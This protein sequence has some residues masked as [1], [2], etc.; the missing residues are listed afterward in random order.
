M[1]NY[2]H[3]I[4]KSR[5][6]RFLEDQGRRETWD[7]T[8][9]RYINYFKDRTEGNSSIPWDDLRAAIYNHEVMP[10]MRAMMTAGK[11][12]DRDAVAGY[13]C[14]Y[15]AIDHP[16]AFDE[17]L[18]ILMCGTGVGFSVERQ[19]INKLPEVAEELY[20]TE[21]TI[22]VGDS[23]LGWAKA[24]KQLISMLYDGDIPK[25][26]MSKV[27]PAGARLKTFGGRASGPEP[28]TDLF[29]FTVE[30]FKQAKGRKLNSIEC[31]DI[32]C[33]VADVVICGGV[34]R[35]A[36][37]SLSNLTDE[38]MRNAKSGEWWNTQGQRALANNSVCYTEK[39]DIGIFMREWH[40]LYESKS[41]ERGM[42][43][44]VAS[45]KM[46]PERRDK[47]HDFGTNPSLRKGTKVWT[48]D[49]IFPIEQLEGKSFKVKN[50]NGEISDAICWLSG[51]DVPLYEISLFGG[52]KYYATAEHKWP[53]VVDKKQR[54]IKKFDTKS[55][56]P[57]M[58]LPVADTM[59]MLTEGKKGSYDDGFIV[60]WNL[61]D[62]WITERKN[63]LKQIGFIVS[64]NDK[65][66]GI[67]QMITD[68]LREKCNYS[69]DGFV[70]GRTELN[71]NSQ[72]LRELFS[73]HGV[74][75]KSK[76]LPE[77]VWTSASEEFRRG[78][79]NGLFSSDGSIASSGVGR[80][81]K[82]VLTSSHEKLISDVSELLGFYGIKTSIR[83]STNVSSFPNGKK[84]NREYERFD[85]VIED[86]YSKKVFNKLFSLS[87]QDKKQLLDDDV[88]LVTEETVGQLA[89]NNR[90]LVK[91]K[92]IKLTS[93]TEDVWDISVKDNTHCFQ[94]AH[95]ITGNCSE[96]V[97]RNKQFCNLSEVV[98]R[99]SD[100]KQSLL[101]KVEFATILGTLQST[102][103][104][105]RYLSK[106][107]KTN[108]EEERLLGVSLTGIMDHKILSDKDKMGP[109]L[110]EMRDVAI[111][112]N[113]KYAKLL[114]IPQSTAIT[115]TKPSGT[116][117]QL[118]DSASGI[119]PR[120]SEYYVRTVRA[121]KKDPLATWM[122]EKGF[123]VEEDVMFSNNWVFSFPQKAPKNS[124]MR[125]DMGAIDQLEHWAV[126]AKEWCEHKPSI[127]VYVREDEWLDV[128]AWV[129]KHFDIVNGVSFL[130]HTDHTYRQ[131][132][133]QEITEEEYN[134][135]VKKMPTDIDF[136]EFIEEVDNTTSSQELACSSAAGCE[137]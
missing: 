124:V 15:L 49:G 93:L 135:L 84:Y 137:I 45:Q 95:C 56:Q 22:V 47:D 10:S 51:K 85:L 37:L 38:R 106:A 13:N 68:Y 1:D 109:W 115:C 88:N 7:E 23:K 120:Y 54:S 17:I 128:G 64:E 80:P 133:Y 25:W 70:E 14:S 127:T 34:R 101:R 113:K 114:G 90:G 31:H 100:T 130:P 9:D 33:K 32:V 62:G 72:T 112:C 131:A 6:A 105:F 125:D 119:H 103:T 3:Y 5:Y 36:L 21:T 82:I 99:P 52:H 91:I 89:K 28:L 16:R 102:L 77:S 50:L 108:T 60:G 75:H 65:Q 98:V 55:L 29:R 2:R 30:V 104:D 129:Y 44:R 53:V 96:I 94:L 87:H 123:P 24:Y 111:E 11:A 43:N 61:G 20:P 83:H 26:D 39:P 74:T 81:K 116:V 71:V 40:S 63:G 121:D 41:G 67:D 4:H 66:S 46:A 48:K 59:D 132:P 78:L 18:Y 12:L 110:N 86:F 69:G 42:F 8:V 92:E 76:G 134:D 57:G 107:W 136:A 19:F 126:M 118:V 97:L 58:Y 27:R 117:S 122:I 79:I 73:S 35:S